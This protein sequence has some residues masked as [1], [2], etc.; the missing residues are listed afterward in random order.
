MTSAQTMTNMNVELRIQTSK[1]LRWIQIASSPHLEG[2]F[3]V[4]DGFLLEITQRKEADN[5]LKAEKNRLQTLGDNIPGGTLYQVTRDMR[6]GQMK[7]TYAS[8][9]WEAVT[10]LSRDEVLADIS[11]VFDSMPPEDLPE[12]MR[13]IEESIRTMTDHYFETRIGGRWVH[14]VGRP[15]RE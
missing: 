9:T 1:A 11:K 14:F 6:T 8:A 5:E 3:V 13:T 7:S 2:Q 10:G 15:R 12:L 4:W